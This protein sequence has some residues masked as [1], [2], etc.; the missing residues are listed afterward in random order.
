MGDYYK[1][2]E[3]RKSKEVDLIK[4]AF[5]QAIEA[6]QKRILKLL[7]HNNLKNSLGFVFRN[8]RIRTDEPTPFINPS[9][10]DP[11]GVEKAIQ[12]IKGEIEFLLECHNKAEE[13]RI[14]FSDQ[15]VEAFA[16]QFK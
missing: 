9:T 15:R 5:E 1:S 8:G 6:K 13:M 7:D 14:H 10:S 16:K 3:Y 11:E 4:F 2:D 12:R